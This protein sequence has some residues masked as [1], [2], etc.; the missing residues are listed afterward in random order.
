MMTY[1]LSHMLRKS[2]DQ[3]VGVS[4]I[5]SRLGQAILML[6]NGPSGI[7]GELVGALDQS[8]HRGTI[9]VL[10]QRRSKYR[11]RIH[12]DIGGRRH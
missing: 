2:E 3:K 6:P 5:D 9:I 4:A 1:P 7:D 8:G 12:R 10:A 11:D